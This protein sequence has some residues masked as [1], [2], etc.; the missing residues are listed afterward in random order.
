MDE[1]QLEDAESP[2]TVSPGGEPANLPYQD[3]SLKHRMILGYVWTFFGYGASQVLRFGSGI[4]TRHL[5]LPEVFG[6]MGMVNTTLQGLQM[7]SE[8]GIGASIVQHPK[9]EDAEFLR[10]AWTIHV[11]RGFTLWL[12]ACLLTLPIARFYEEVPLLWLIPAGTLTVLIDGFKSMK[13][14][15]LARRLE[16]RVLTII[17]LSCQAVTITV[18]IVWAWLWPSVWALVAGALCG[19]ALRVTFSHLVLGPP[20]MRFAFD[21]DIAKKL[22]HFGKWLFLSTILTFLIGFIDKG[23]L[24]KLMEN[25]ASFG[26]YM[27]A[28]LFSNAMVDVVRKVSQNVLFPVYSRLAEQGSER[29]RTQTL[30]IRRLMLL[31]TLPPVWV[32]IV[33]G[34]E[35]I[36]LLLPVEFAA[37]GGY[38]QL[39][40]IG[41]LFSTVLIPVGSVLLAAGDSFRHMLCQATQSVILVL[42]MIVGAYWGGGTG[43][44]LI[45]GVILGFVSGSFL[46][47]PVLAILVRK[48]NVWFPGLDFLAVA[49]SGA[50]IGIGFWLKSLWV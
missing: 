16:I 49:V 5:L 28:C 38:L 33:W 44:G 31:A 11:L 14:F 34:P 22:I 46:Y 42:A 17:D 41:T 29:L 21:P 47:Y 1:F 15:T 2:E 24:G 40:A 9:G 32:L 35:I 6:L 45:N 39:L 19:C 50:A 27:T 43:V 26:V 30:R 37:A 48:Y 10:T 20:R 4:V 8:M 18:T 13:F 3:R 25:M 23:V 7:C 36:D 12:C